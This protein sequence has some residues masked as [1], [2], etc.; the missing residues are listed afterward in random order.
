MEVCIFKITGILPITKVK[1]IM[2]KSNEGRFKHKGKKI[3]EIIY[4]L[5]YNL[6]V[7]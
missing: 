5:C 2:K 4:N 6:Q 1:Q 7:N 3:V